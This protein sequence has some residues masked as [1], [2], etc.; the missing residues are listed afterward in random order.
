MCLIRPV[1][2]SFGCSKAGF[3]KM[4]GSDLLEG[5]NKRSSTGSTASGAILVVQWQSGKRFMQVALHTPLHTV[6]L[7]KQERRQL[8]KGQS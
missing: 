1:E 5:L 8:L 4:V 2:S 3:D 6:V 7:S